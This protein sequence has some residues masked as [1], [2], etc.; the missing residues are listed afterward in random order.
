MKKIALAALALIA[1][2]A[3]AG[4]GII[5]ANNEAT[6]SVG[7]HNLDYTEETSDGGWPGT[8]DSEKGN[9]AAFGVAFTH[10]GWVLGIPNIYTSV[11]TVLSTG[12]TSYEGYLQDG[13][14][15]LTPY[16]GTTHNV[17]YDLEL[18][19]GKGLPIGTSGQFQVTPYLLYN[20]HHWQRQPGGT[21]T[22]DYSH[23]AIGAGVL[24]QIAPNPY[25]VFS[26][27][28]SYS[29]M[30]GAQV[31]VDSVP[32]MDLQNKPIAKLA[33]GVDYAVTSHFHLN[34]NYKYTSFNY[35]GSTPVNVS[36]MSVWEPQSKTRENLFM[37][38]AS[39]AY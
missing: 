23:N 18:R 15:D 31:N 3:H 24:A 34:A 12:S 26:A 25:L 28:F 38:G 7:V 17:Q 19:V 9:Q 20:Y 16:S 13:Y 22:E 27:D 36:G 5:G 39:Y 11:S 30:L 2:S 33:L 6:F 32:T 1:S 21:Y 35:G 37:V 29:A 8:L 4:T 10:Q 14:G